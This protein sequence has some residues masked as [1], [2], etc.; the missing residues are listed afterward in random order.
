M[1]EKSPLEKK[2]NSFFPKQLNCLLCKV[3]DVYL[4]SGLKLLFFLEIFRRKFNF[5]M[6]RWDEWLSSSRKKAL[7]HTSK[8]T[9]FNWNYFSKASLSKLNFN[10][11][12][13]QIYSTSKM[14]KMD[15]CLK[16]AYRHSFDFTSLVNFH[17]T[18]IS[19]W[20]CEQCDRTPS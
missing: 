18:R 1:E 4:L 13:L 6:L 2:L 15:F 16:F 7:L 17:V 3:H 11:E 12:Y 20:V 19:A 14:A 5:E 10:I 8:K 9:F